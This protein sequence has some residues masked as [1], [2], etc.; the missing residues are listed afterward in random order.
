MP[1]GMVANSTPPLPIPPKGAPCATT[2]LSS[3]RPLAKR[4]FLP[5]P[6]LRNLLLHL[7]F[8]IDHP[9]F[10]R[11]FISLKVYVM[12]VRRPNSTTSPVVAQ[13][14]GRVQV[15]LHFPGAL[16]ACLS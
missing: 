16:E 3:D 15:V 11:R 1:C 14:E 4:R 9:L 2:S 8:S 6:S 7:G 13:K 5:S 10:K 12:M